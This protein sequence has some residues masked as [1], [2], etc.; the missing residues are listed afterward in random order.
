MI[1]RL[2]KPLAFLNPEFRRRITKALPER[3][4][5]SL[6]YFERTPEV[7]M[8]TTRTDLISFVSNVE[9]SPMK[10]KPFKDCC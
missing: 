6:G 7:A 5:G 10:L 9:N 3:I 1:R 8:A 2:S 4:S